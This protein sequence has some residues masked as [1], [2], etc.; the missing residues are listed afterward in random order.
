MVFGF[1]DPR[2]SKLLP[3]WQDVFKSLSLDV[4]YVVA[5]RNPL[6]VAESLKKRDGFD[7]VASFYLWLEHIVLSMQSTKNCNR[8]VVD[9]D[10]IVEEPISQIK[11]IANATSLEFDENKI[12]LGDYC[13]DFLE[14]NLR[15]YIYSLQDLE[16][17][18]NTPDILID[19]YSIMHKIANDEICSQDNYVKTFFDD[20]NDKLL[21]IAPAIDYIDR[22]ILDNKKNISD[23]DKANHQVSDLNHQVSDLNHQVSDLN[24]QLQISRLALEASKDVIKEIKGSKSWRFSS[25]FRVFF[26][27]LRRFREIISESKSYFLIKKLFEVI[28]RKGINYALRKIIQKS[29][30]TK[31]KLDFYNLPPARISSDWLGNNPLVSILI[32]NWNG[33]DHFDALFSSLKKQNYNNYEVIVVDNNS[34]D[35]SVEY[36]K[37]N[38]PEFKLIELNFNSGFAYA[39]NI[40]FENSKGSLIALL[41]TDT[42]VHESWLKELV[43]TVKQNP[44]CVA[45]APKILFWSRYQTVVIRPDTL[46]R[47]RFDSLLDSLKYKKVF[48]RSRHM[49]SD[50]LIIIN[51]LEELVL[52][53]PIQEKSLLFDF[54][55]VNREC[56]ITLSFSEMEKT[57]YLDKLTSS[58]ELNLYLENGKQ[59]FDIINNA[60]SFEAKRMEPADRG[61]AERDLGQFNSLG[62]V[63]YICGCSALIR[64]DAVGLNP[65]FINDFF[66]YY[67][68]TEL[69]VRL[70]VKGEILYNPHSIVWHKHSAS[71]KEKSANW[72]YFV[73][74]N[75]TLFQY[76]LIDPSCR[77]NYLSKAERRFEDEQKSVLRSASGDIEKISYAK[78]I[79]DLILDL[80][81]IT[82][83]IDSGSIYE[84]ESLRIGIFNAH[85]NTFGG[86]EA[87]ALMFAEYLQKYGFVDLLGVEPFSISKLSSYF[88]VNLKKTRK[89]I[90]PNFTEEY[91]SE[92]D[93]FINSSH[94]SQTPSKANISFYT[95]SFPTKSPSKNFLDSYLFMPNSEFTANWAKRYWGANNFQYKRIYPAVKSN[96]AEINFSKKRKLILSVGR[97]CIDGHNKNQ[98]ELA[99]AFVRAKKTDPNLKDWKLVLAG[100][101]KKDRPQDVKYFEKTASL[102]KKHDGLALK[103]ISYDQ[104]QDLY[105]QA[106]IYWHATG[107]NRDPENEPELFEHFGMTVLE[108]ASSGCMPMVFN[109][110]GPKEIVDALGVGFVWNNLEELVT[111]LHKY[112]L[113]SDRTPEKAMQERVFMTKAARNFSKEN[114]TKEFEKILKAKL[115][116]F[117]RFNLGLYDF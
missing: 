24:H 35:G 116:S 23:F 17:Q 82:K 109:A 100:S 102:I 59:D 54:Y 61:F 26:N 29:L 73:N 78:K 30:K 66:T 91:S 39:N 83:K 99:K 86:G 14:N 65:L 75:R 117:N 79:P 53:I 92:Y 41:N 28:N 36:I 32:V 19:A 81:R 44:S 90:I 71:S 34:Q 111:H 33:I 4:Y 104:L 18:A 69:S 84:R 25:P 11:R 94:G 72:Y 67:E 47:L 8:V 12:I 45:V 89:R 50:G 113:M 64:R 16:F 101:L 2:T 1:K 107:L 103:N 62:K 76:L 70:N 97:W 27:Y 98:Y 37:F 52:D 20:I 7:C 108:A 13:K 114:S 105:G 10:L 110:A 51:S 93:I 88:D 112:I 3:F 106:S 40:A 85:W 60:G 56:Q 74:R 95:I 38:H 9:Y 22:L 6:S 46:V 58:F 80:D 77:K 5:L 87:H 63:D 96:N 15:H 43:S 48:I 68:D 49:Q 55:G 42:R 31:F 21:S 115:K 57:Y